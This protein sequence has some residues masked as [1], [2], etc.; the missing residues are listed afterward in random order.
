MSESGSKATLVPVQSSAIARKGS[1]TLVKRG[2]SDL[3]HPESA[4]EW[5]ERAKVHRTE[6]RFEEF[7]ACLQRVIT[8]DPQ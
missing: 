5:L 6:H 7:F 1:A 4:E 2:L 8:L 3:R